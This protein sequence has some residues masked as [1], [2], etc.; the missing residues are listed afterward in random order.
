[1]SSRRW[2]LVGLGAGAR[3]AVLN[4]VEDQLPVAVLLGA[5]ARGAGCERMAS[6]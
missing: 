2:V 5:L 4:G 1:V 6:G 3:Q